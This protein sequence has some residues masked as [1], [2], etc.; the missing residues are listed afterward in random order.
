M[1]FSVNHTQIKKYLFIYIMYHILLEKFRQFTI[2]IVL[3]FVDTGS[4]K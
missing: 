2:I 4:K 3:F 1:Y